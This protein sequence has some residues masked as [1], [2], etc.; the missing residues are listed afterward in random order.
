MPTSTSRL[1]TPLLIVFGLVN[2]PLSMLM[3][4][5]AAVLPNFDRDYSAITLAG[6]ATAMLVARRLASCP[7]TPK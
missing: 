4:S 3:S 1:P 5:T 6:L 7:E 2:L